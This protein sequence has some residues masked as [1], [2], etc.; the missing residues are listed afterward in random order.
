MLPVS[1][2]LWSYLLAGGCALWVGLAFGRTA[3]MAE[4]LDAS[5]SEVRALGVR[6]IGS[7]LALALS[8]HKG[9]AIALRVGFD[10]ADAAKYGRGKPRVLAMTAGFA[11]FGAI[12]LLARRD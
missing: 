7:G 6:D 3:R 5:E 4:M 1:R 2:R 9:T 12:G 10:L 11:A 8:P